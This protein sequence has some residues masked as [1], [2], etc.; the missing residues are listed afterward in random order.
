MSFV[1]CPLLG[2]GI[3]LWQMAGGTRYIVQLIYYAVVV[4]G[5]VLADVQFSRLF[6]APYLH[7]TA[8]RRTL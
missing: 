8:S 4:S 1:E 3:S 2:S 6:R 7:I 5:V